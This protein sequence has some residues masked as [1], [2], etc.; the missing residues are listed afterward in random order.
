MAKWQISSEQ[1]AELAAAQADARREG[2]VSLFERCLGI[3]MFEQ[4]D[5]PLP[6]QR[7][8]ARTSALLSA[9]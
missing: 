2:D 9:G 6:L 7:S 3:G 8:L 1:L 4:L 5:S